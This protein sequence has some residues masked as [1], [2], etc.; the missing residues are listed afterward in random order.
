MRS[1]AGN[2]SAGGRGSV[3][4]DWEANR[5]HIACFA[6]SILSTYLPP[7]SPY[8]LHIINAI[9]H[10][11]QNSI[12]LSSTPPSN[13]RGGGGGG[14]GGGAGGGG[15]G[16]GGAPPAHNRQ[17]FKPPLPKNREIK[18]PPKNFLPAP[19]HL[20]RIMLVVL[21][22]GLSLTAGNQNLDHIPF[23]NTGDIFSNPFPFGDF[24]KFSPVHPR[25]RHV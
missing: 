13:T 25:P 7:A 10:P 24:V 11:V 12:F 16:G 9:P 5:E 23:K 18:L 2:E 3:D 21:K 17:A 4:V 6:C 1:G 15:G 22:S 19:V 20:Q 8:F 14:G